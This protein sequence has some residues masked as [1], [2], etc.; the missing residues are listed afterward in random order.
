MLIPTTTTGA[1]MVNQLVKEDWDTKRQEYLRVV[2]GH[3]T[4]RLK[5][6]EISCRKQL[7]EAQQL[8]DD[9]KSTATRS[10]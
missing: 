3:Y 5:Q 9:G 7:F 6:F 8:E 1:D 2:L 10:T 4:S